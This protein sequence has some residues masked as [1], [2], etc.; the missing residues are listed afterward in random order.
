MKKLFTFLGATAL[1]AMSANAATFQ[2]T[3]N[4]MGPGEPYQNVI[5]TTDRP[6]EAGGTPVE[7]TS[8]QPTIQTT[9]L[10][11]S[12]KGGYQISSVSSPTTGI[13]DHYDYNAPGYYSESN[14][15]YYFTINPDAI[16]S[17]TFNITVLEGT[18]SGPDTTYPYSIPVA[19]SDASV[20]ESA[21]F[22][23][24]LLA[25][26]NAIVI[27]EDMRGDNGT[28][29][30]TFKEGVEISDYTAS[31]VNAA[32]TTVGL[33]P[34]P[35]EENVLII[36]SIPFTAQSVSVEYTV[37]DANSENIVKLA[38]TGM[39]DAE[40][41][42]VVYKSTY[43]GN[44]YIP[45]QVQ[46]TG[47]TT[48][49]VLGE[50]R[51]VIFISAKEG[52]SLI[53][54]QVNANS[55][56]A[57]NPTLVELDA[58]AQSLSSTYGVDVKVGD[59][60]VNYDAG[61]STFENNAT[62]T[63][64]VG[65]EPFDVTF[66][67]IGLAN[68]Y[69]FVNVSTSN[70]TE[71]NETLSSDT[72]TLKVASPYG[73]TAFYV[74][75]KDGY[76]VKSISSSVPTIVV[77]TAAG[78]GT[79]GMWDY[80]DYY[81]CYIFSIYNDE[82]N[83]NAVITIELQ[84]GSGTTEPTPEPET[85][86]IPV[87]YSDASLVANV[88]FAGTA[89]ANKGEIVAEYDPSNPHASAT[90]YL[91][92][93][94]VNGAE[95]AS[96]NVSLTTAEGTNVVEA[97][98]ADGSISVEINF[99]QVTK[100]NVEFV[101]SQATDEPIVT[102]K[103]TGVENAYEYVLKGSSPEDEDPIELTGTPEYEFN[104]S[105]GSL[106]LIPAEGYMFKSITSSVATITDGSADGSTGYWYT[107]N[108]YTIF[109]FQDVE[110]NYGAVITIEVAQGSSTP[111]NPMTKYIPV[112][113]NLAAEV[114]YAAFNGE[115]LDNKA[116]IE[117][118]SD[119]HGEFGTLTVYLVEGSE[120]DG[121]TAYYL[122]DA[123]EQVAIV[124]AYYT[125][126]DEEEGTLAYITIPNIPYEVATA[127]YVTLSESSSNLPGE[128]IEVS[129]NLYTQGLENAAYT[130][131]ASVT[132]DGDEIDLNANTFD[133]VYS[134]SSVDVVITLKEGYVAE[135][136]TSE[137]LEAVVYNQDNVFTIILMD[138]G[139]LNNGG[140]VD[141]MIMDKNS[142]GIGSIYQINNEDAVYTIQGVKVN[143]ENLKPGI[144]VINGKKVMLK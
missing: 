23:G 77:S 111:E 100:V 134:E 102:F 12:P 67:F 141:L 106:Y 41:N 126:A 132:V 101:S 47:G 28:L 117:I 22:N 48:D 29:A 64:T 61:M 27:T 8:N 43:D 49:V 25:N 103:F 53:S 71:I 125:P 10:Y 93:T 140:Y 114:E 118:T 121:A 1:C 85:Y 116:Q 13:V 7:L 17:A 97:P 135:Y 112:N 26:P 88:S 87:T 59:Y 46:L 79:T 56:Y 115:V 55:P 14:G 21:T 5:V 19:Y 96:A 68:A 65:L 18:N 105:S 113:Y 42:V 137:Y 86:T 75:A 90:G 15:T 110:A 38:F 31:Y 104:L 99:T 16:D 11:V 34:Y 70:P 62:I 2:I 63:F 127:V 33:Y 89:L 128:E 60:Y 94:L 124:G 39:T 3:L 73:A 83:A 44:G 6:Y 91:T 92:I 108:G 109:T 32:G 58:Q 107:Y 98:V 45:A 66:K 84:S 120:V 123:E 4:L 131:I 82:A 50:T 9:S 20:I 138:N 37:A 139:L 130:Y 74:K 54:A 80:N 40:N 143:K 119:T 81:N 24:T 51:G 78:D 129:F 144:Y 35:E 72:Y 36:Y 133:V 30:L 57:Y 52:S 136:R 69:E 95:V 76:S 142:S 122:N